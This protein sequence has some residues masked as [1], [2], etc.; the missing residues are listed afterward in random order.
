M[1]PEEFE[2]MTT[3]EERAEMEEGD[4]TLVPPTDGTLNAASFRWIQVW[5]YE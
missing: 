1:D 3:P 2:A 5:S 4:Q